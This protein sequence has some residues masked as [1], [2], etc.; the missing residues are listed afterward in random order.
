[1]KLISHGIKYL[2]AILSI[3][4]VGSIVAGRRSKDT[5]SSHSSHVTTVELTARLESKL[6][7]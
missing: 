6:K 7:I 4:F 1:M 5:S 3:A 2:R